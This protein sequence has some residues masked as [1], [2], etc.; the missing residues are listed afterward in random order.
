MDV[1]TALGI[2]AL[3]RGEQLSASPL[4]RKKAVFSSVASVGRSPE[5][6]NLLV[7]LGCIAPTCTVWTDH[8]LAEYPSL[9]LN[10]RVN[11]ECF[12]VF[13]ADDLVTPEYANDL[14]TIKHAGLEY[15]VGGLF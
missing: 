14:E 9:F 10:R 8:T 2:Y 5:V 3:P 4:M 11:N 1:R 7:A 12:W 13:R 6:P 15:A